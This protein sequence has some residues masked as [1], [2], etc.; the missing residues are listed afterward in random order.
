M[1]KFGQVGQ[2]IHLPRF[3]IPFLKN[4]FGFDVK[5]IL[6][7]KNGGLGHFLICNGQKKPKMGKKVGFGQ[8]GQKICLLTKI[9]FDNDF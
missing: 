3:F 5:W 1:A 2:I 9:Q 4:S 8:I 6:E 7:S